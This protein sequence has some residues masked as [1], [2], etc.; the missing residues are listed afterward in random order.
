VIPTDPRGSPRI[1]F[2]F[3]SRLVRPWQRLTKKT[4]FMYLFVF[5][6][7]SLKMDAESASKNC[8]GVVRVQ[9]T[10]TTQT[11]Y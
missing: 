2:A 5:V 10:L 6:V 4:V 11:N 9:G 1:T 3:L 7:F 8:Q